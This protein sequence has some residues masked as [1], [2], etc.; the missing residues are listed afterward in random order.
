MKWANC[1]IAANPGADAWPR[2]V[3][4]EMAGWGDPLWDAAGILQEYLIAWARAGRTAEQVAVPMRAFWTAYAAGDE[5]L[6]RA[7]GYAA[8][9]MIQSAYEILK[10]E[11]EMTAAPIRLLQAALNILA[12]PARAVALFF[13]PV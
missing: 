9:R 8:A 4:W 2:F 5:S 12:T 3:D 13:G 7:L 11:E 1:L 6:E 10:H